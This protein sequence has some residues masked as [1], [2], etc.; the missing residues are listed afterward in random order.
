MHQRKP[1]RI[2]VEVRHRILPRDGNPA[3]IHL[4]LHEL[5]IGLRQE[6]VERQCVAQPFR[7]LEFESVIVI[8]ELN[9]SLLASLARFVKQ[10]DRLLVSLGVAVLHFKPRA[11][12]ILVADHI[13]SLQRLGHLFSICS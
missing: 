8:R 11:N 7:L 12:Q 13:R 2:F 9:T 10:L 1:P 5:R 3:Q 6:I 4:E